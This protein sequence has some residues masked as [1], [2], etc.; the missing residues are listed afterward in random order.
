[1]STINYVQLNAAKSERTVA[2][3]QQLLADFQVYY[4]N[5]RNYH[6][7]IKGEAFFA[8]HSKFE[9]LYDDAAEKTDEIA[10]RILMLGGTPENRFSAYLKVAKIKEVETTS[11]V[12]VI[13]SNILDNLKEFIA[14]ERTLLAFASEAGDESTV[15]L[16]SDY[17]GEQ[18]KLVWMLV[19]SKSE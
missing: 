10:E 4:T 19:A 8:L 11:D 18:E 12:K 5:L 17:L 7:N 16:M 9:E 1:M 6:W 13:I 2:M 14:Q 3:L 15:S